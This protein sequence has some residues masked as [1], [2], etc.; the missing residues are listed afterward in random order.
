[1]AAEH[2]H[3]PIP[4]HVYVHF[5]LPSQGVLHGGG[6]IPKYMGIGPQHGHGIFGNLFGA[7]SRTART[8]IFPSLVRLGKNVVGDV[9]N[10]E[11]VESSA[12]RRVRQQFGGGKKRKRRSKRKAIIIAKKKSGKKKK[13]VSRKKSVGKKTRKRKSKKSS[14]KQSIS[15]RNL[16]Q[17]SARKNPLL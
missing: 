8:I 2:Q 4:A 16:I 13:S 15:L 5:L 10:G 14:G 17:H 12:T 7:L 9:M 6:S 3:S 11:S 1:M